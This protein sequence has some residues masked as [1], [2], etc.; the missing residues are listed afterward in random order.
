MELA[1]QSQEYR[2]NPGCVLLA[3]IERA[4]EKVMCSVPWELVRVSPVFLFSSDN[5]KSL[6]LKMNI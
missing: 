5:H 2:Y 6:S 3:L 1:I 4:D